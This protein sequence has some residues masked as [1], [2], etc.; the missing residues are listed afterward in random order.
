MK[1]GLATGDDDGGGGKLQDFVDYLSL[2]HGRGGSGMES[3]AEMATE[4]A[5]G[6][7]EEDGGEAGMEA[8]TLD[9]V[10]YFLTS[11]YFEV[12]K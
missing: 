10:E 11:S 12:Q 4:V 7:S 8:F 1:G 5:P 9:A 2:G 6:E 3:V